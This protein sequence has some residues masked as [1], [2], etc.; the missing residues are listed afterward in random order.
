MRRRHNSVRCSRG[1]LATLMVAGGLAL[2]SM[3][4][5][6]G[7]SSGATTS[8]GA[9]GG[10][11]SPSV[12]T[13]AATAAGAVDG[14]KLLTAA[15]AS[16]IVGFKYS[17]ATDGGNGMCSYATTAAPI[18]LFIIVESN[19]GGSAAWTDQLQTLQ[20]DAGSKPVTLSGVGD[21]A[22]VAGPDRRPGR[23]L[24]HRRA[25]RRSERHRRHVPQVDRAGQGDHHQARVTGSV[26]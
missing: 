4:A 22:A 24:H 13:T 12:D 23:Q 16:K 20:E 8:S 6:G 21:R 10:G 5:C 19:S 26:G 18:P 17:S 9:S 3:T 15:E 1:R 25:R 14:C 7:S 11:S 2:I